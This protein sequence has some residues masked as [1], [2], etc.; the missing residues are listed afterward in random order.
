MR[1]AITI[2]IEHKNPAS[3]WSCTQM[4]PRGAGP[5][6]WG[7]EQTKLDSGVI[8]VFRFKCR[9]GS[10]AKNL[11]GPYDPYQHFLK[12]TVS[13]QVSQNQVFDEKPVFGKWRCST[14]W[15]CVSWPEKNCGVPPSAERRFWVYSRIFPKFR[16][17]F[18]KISEKC[19]YGVVFV[20]IGFSGITSPLRPKKSKIL[21]KSSAKKVFHSR[22]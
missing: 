6:V 11:H 22:K 10:V 13:R 19:I 20:F 2:T 3:P 12:G 16:H 4:T 18:I 1:N 21:R 7:K 9:N 5:Y 15:K 14:C 8:W 17:L